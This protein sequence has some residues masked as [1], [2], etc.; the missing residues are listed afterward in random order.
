MSN[1]QIL[2]KNEEGLH[3][4]IRLENKWVKKESFG[5]ENLRNEKFSE[6]KVLKEKVRKENV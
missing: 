4:R 5:K 1:D 3:G 6:E 2:Y